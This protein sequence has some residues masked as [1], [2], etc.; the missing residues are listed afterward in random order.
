M[1]D[2]FFLDTGQSLRAESGVW[3]R[4]LQILGTGGNAVT[5]LVVATSGP[6]RGV[7]FALKVF[8]RLSKPERRQA[9]LN[10]IKFLEQCDHPCI[11]RVF[12]NGVFYDQHPFLVAEYLPGTLYSLMRAGGISVVVKISFALQLLSALAYL[13]QLDTPVIHRD[14]K[15]KNIFVKG[16]S[17][18]LGD[19]GLL[20]HINAETAEDREVFKESVGFGMPFRYRTPDQV[21][22]FRGEAAI[23]AKSDVFQLGLVLAE[24]FT[25]RNPERPATAFDAPVEIDAL[26]TIPGALSGGIASVI[27]RM[28][29][30]DPNQRDSAATFMDPWEGIFRAA[31]SQAHALE[32]HAIG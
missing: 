15:P 26:G 14:I 1:A 6:N 24:L 19:F 8:R 17:A 11:M 7:P 5:F 21:A 32:G 10:E 28:L 9:F 13:H 16:R 31:V 25:R 4:N 23:T 20:K 18:V 3:Y 22:Y 12:D 29:A 2:S 30:R 27:N